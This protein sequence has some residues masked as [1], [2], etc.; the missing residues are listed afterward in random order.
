MSPDQNPIENVWRLMK[1]KI[2]KKKNQVGSWIEGRTRK[3]MEPFLPRVSSQTGGQHETSCSGP[4]V[5]EW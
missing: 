4:Y 3:G 1:I 2:Q 5:R